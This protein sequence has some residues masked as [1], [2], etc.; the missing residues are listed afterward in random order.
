MS[1]AATGGSHITPSY[2]GASAASQQR[3]EEETTPSG[4]I[5]ALR[6]KFAGSAPI[7]FASTPSPSHHE[8]PEQ[9]SFEPPSRP[10]IGRVTM[11]GLPDRQSE[12]EPEQEEEEIPRQ[13]EVRIPSPPPQ[14]RSPTPPTPEV[15][16]SPI[17]VAMPVARRDDPTELEKPTEPKSFAPVES[18]SK[19][20]PREEELPEE[21]PVAAPTGGQGGIRATV[22]YDYE[23]QEDNEIDLI[24]NQVVTAIDMVDEDW[25]AGTNAQGKSGLFPSNY[26]EIIQEDAAEEKTAPPRSPSPEPAAPAAPARAEPAK[27]TPASAGPSAIALYDYEA[28]ED[29]EISFPEGATITDLEFPDDDWWQGTYKGK[30][31]LFP[32]NYVELQQ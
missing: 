24:E 15:P 3:E 5:G 8:E 21:P 19:V 14:P 1:P 17:R 10:S 25:W 6:N 11:P 13:E 7:G 22:L 30:E 9:R 23:A 4:G 16:G 18:L 29:N 32:A 20:V 2:T 12:P 31:G 26:V 28:Q 27:P